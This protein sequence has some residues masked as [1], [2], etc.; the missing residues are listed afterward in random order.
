MKLRLREP[1]SRE[2]TWVL[3]ADISD[4][5]TLH[6]TCRH[7]GPPVNLKHLAEEHPENMLYLP[8]NSLSLESPRTQDPPMQPLKLFL[9]GRPVAPTAPGPQTMEES[10]WAQ[11]NGKS[12]SNCNGV[13]LE[14]YLSL[15]LWVPQCRHWQGESLWKQNSQSW[16]LRRGRVQFLLWLPAALGTLLPTDMGDGAAGGHCQAYGTLL[17]PTW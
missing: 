15:G 16:E 2:P 12:S 10:S 13:N 6:T 17:W 7:W 3:Y 5:F 4:S 9:C 11:E 1:W 14:C 8:L